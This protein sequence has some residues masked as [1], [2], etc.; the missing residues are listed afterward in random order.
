MKKIF[1][2]LIFFILAAFIFGI[3]F[4]DSLRREYRNL[5]KIASNGSLNDIRFIRSGLSQKISFY[6]DSLRIAGELYDSQ[7]NSPCIILLHGSSIYGRKSPLVR[8]LANQ[9]NRLGYVVLT[10]DV[11]GYGESEDPKGL[12]VP[13]DF[14]FARDV[15][16]GIDYLLSNVSIDT[17]RIYVIGHSFGGGVALAAQMR[18]SRIKKL[19]LIGPS[20]RLKERFFNSDAMDREYFLKRW[21]RDMQLSYKLTF[22][23]WKEVLRPLDIEWHLPRF[24]SLGHV[25]IFLIDGERENKK[26][27]EFLRCIYQ[28][29]AP[30]A[31]YWTIPKTA[32]YLNTGF[33]L[34]RVCYNRRVVVKAVKHI[35]KW[36]K[37]GKN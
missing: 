23:I 22:A 5:E 16:S 20:R 14:D 26:D 35:D 7:R 8:V 2:V 3:S 18:D 12:E 32:H 13:D 24:Q 17:Q 29:M 30:P 37:K 36:L 28:K 15:Q 1:S 34:G 11:R 10:F 21:R 33:F 27:I 19:V 9:F 25:P 31:D 4:R 6:S